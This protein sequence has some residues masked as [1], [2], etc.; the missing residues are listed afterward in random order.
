M[1]DALG[2][3]SIDA[4]F[5][6][7]PPPS[8]RRRP[9]PAGRPRRALAGAPHRGSVAPQPGR[10][11]QLPGRRRL[12]PPH[13]GHGRPD[14]QP[15]RVLHRLHALPARDQPGHAADDLRVPVADRRADRARRCL[16]VALRRRRRD[17]RGGADDRPR[18]RAASASSSAAPS[19]ATSATRRGPTSRAVGWHSRSCP[20]WPTA[21]PT[22]T[23][24][25]ARW[26]TPDHPVAGVLLGQPNAFGILEPMAEAAQLAHAAGALFVAV[27]EPV[28]LAVL[29]PPGEYGADI[30]VGRGPAAGHSRSSTAGP[31]WACWRRASDLVRQVPGRLVGRTTDID[32]RRAFVMTL[33]A[34]E[35]DIRRDKAASNICTNQ[36]LCALAATV[37]LATLGPHGLRDVAALGAARAKQLEAA[38]AGVGVERVHS[39]RL[40]ERVRRARARRA[41]RPCRAARAWLP[42]RPAAGRL[43]SRRSALA[44]ALLVCA[45]EVD[46]ERRHRALC[47]SALR[48]ATSMTAAQRAAAGH[49][50]RTSPKAASGHRPRARRRA[51]LQPTLAELVQPGRG[52][53]KVP[54]PPA[55]ALE[56]IPAEQRR[57]DAAGPAGAERA[58]R[59]PPL[60]QPLAAQLLDRHRL[61]SARLVH[62]EVQP[63][64]QR[65][66]GPAAGLRG[67]PSARARRDRAGHAR[68][69]VGARAVADRDQRHA[70]RSRSS[71][72]PARMA[73]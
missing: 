42:R 71:R 2:I 46:H 14:P 67:A 9:G 10:P 38:L 53:T 72:R 62:D 63:Q 51:G 61:L 49:A 54:H 25:S 45:T 60:R 50:A 59:H 24:W 30:A 57:A 73:S 66:G 1:L 41:A 6:D 20:R 44:D 16:G 23:P 36:A 43:V 22:S 29:A 28:S 19:I 7:I 55:D 68:A 17:G 13:P 47:P 52:S 39:A 48:E 18:R 11:G 40:P 26:P 15:R 69:A 58:G 35:Q 33:R 32:G 65:V 21:R 8:A 27:V 4:L 12:P 70:W 31:T 5:A 34:R 37:Y 56:R 64:D 3:D